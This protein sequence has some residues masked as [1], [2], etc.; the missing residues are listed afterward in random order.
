MVSAQFNP[1]HQFILKNVFLET[2]IFEMAKSD[3]SKT[4]EPI[5]IQLFLKKAATLSILD[6]FFG[7]KLLY[8]SLTRIH[9]EDQNLCSSGAFFLSAFRDLI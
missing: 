2:A 7:C 5:V 9:G 8:F 4:N 6:F 3:N 1:V